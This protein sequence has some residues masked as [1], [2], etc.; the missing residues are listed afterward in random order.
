MT[1]AWAANER[2]LLRKTKLEAEKRVQRCSV[3]VRGRGVE[4]AS[5]GLLGL[6]MSKVPRYADFR[7]EKKRR[8]RERKG[9]ECR[10]AERTLLHELFMSVLEVKLRR[11]KHCR[12]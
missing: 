9:P 11:I 2:E 12:D 7:K 6:F 4:K 3:W 8:E 1:A 5:G 10:K